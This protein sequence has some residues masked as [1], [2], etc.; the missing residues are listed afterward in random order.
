MLPI[1]R[2]IP[3]GG[4]LLAIAITVL[5]LSPPDGSRSRFARIE[6]AA[7]GPLVD[8]A[9]H[10]EWRHFLIQAAL[11]RAGELERLREL[12]DTPPRNE[13]SPDA[14][15][16]LPS[17]TDAEPVQVDG[18]GVLAME[19][20]ADQARTG[21]RSTDA[22]IAPLPAAPILPVDSSDIAILRRPAAPAVKPDAT[23][24]AT[25]LGNAGL[26]I[27]RSDAVTLRAANY[28]DDA[29]A[30]R[31]LRPKLNEVA[32]VIDHADRI[33]AGDDAAALQNSTIT[34]G[35]SAAPSPRPELAA[36]AS[37]PDAATPPIQSREMAAP[38]GTVGTNAPPDTPAAAGREPESQPDEST[39]VAALPPEG[40]G[41]MDGNAGAAEESGNASSDGANIDEAA[42]PGMPVILPRE[43]PSGIA[44]PVQ[45]IRSVRRVR[46][47]RPVRTAANDP[48]TF[49]F[50]E[51]LLRIFSVNAR[52]HG[53]AAIPKR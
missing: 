50:F 42:L 9:A 32:P 19:A 30:A 40:T 49:N 28:T 14:N 20:T 25:L 12:P 17:G 24:F 4:V 2:I 53:G 41:T 35:D 34:E 51:T 18:P 48:A 22:P 46:H 10:P 7:R 15:E 31:E 45:T 52:P 27:K 43:R 13:P 3:V 23:R 11:R 38:H 29:T 1:L 21:S 5:A 37:L 47:T 39:N 44:E 33:V 16:T 36:V 6:V 8:R 26:P